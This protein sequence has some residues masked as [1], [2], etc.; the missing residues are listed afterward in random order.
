MKRRSSSSSS[1][2]ACR[3]SGVAV[4]AASASGLSHHSYATPSKASSALPRLARSASFRGV[5][6]VCTWT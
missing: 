4:A 2:A 6:R 3:P 5:S 1:S